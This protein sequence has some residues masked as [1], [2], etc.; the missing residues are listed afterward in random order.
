MDPMNKAIPAG[1]RVLETG[2]GKFT[3]TDKEWVVDAE[4][5]I[6]DDTWVFFWEGLVFEAKLHPGD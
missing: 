6:E 2:S 3:H 4:H 5:R 1:T